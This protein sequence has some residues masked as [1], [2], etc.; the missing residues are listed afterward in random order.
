MDQSSIHVKQYCVISCHNCTIL[1]HNFIYYTTKMLPLQSTRRLF[2]GFGFFFAQ[3]RAYIVAKSAKRSAVW[4]IFSQD[5]FPIGCVGA[6][7]C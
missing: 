4:G 1:K 6:T 3:S 2:A 5:I 7:P